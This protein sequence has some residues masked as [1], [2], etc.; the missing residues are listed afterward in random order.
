MGL[1]ARLLKKRP[2]DQLRAVL[3]DYSLPTFPQ[4]VLEARGVI[5]DDDSSNSDVADCIV[6]DPGLTVRVIKTVN[7]AAFGVRHRVDSVGQAVALLGRAQVESLLLSH[8]AVAALP[9][10]KGK[11]YKAN[12]FW[13]AAARRAAVARA[14]SSRLHPATAGQSFTA[15]LLQDMAVPV[16]AQVMGDRYDEMLRAYYG[17]EEDLGTMERGEFGWDHAEVGSWMCEAWSFPDLLTA[18]VADHHGMAI[19]DIE[20]PPAVRA[21][22]LLPDE[23]AANDIDR[24]TEFVEQEHGLEPDEIRSIIEIAEVDSDEL[25]RMF[26]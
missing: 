2:E 8:G 3:G 21:V 25:A 26:G 16:L 12:R 15:A 4:I 22:A 1:L 24:F 9:K 20:A 14:L 11:A 10:P 7:A 5:R 19:P 23:P 17:G 18:S 13:R 6:R